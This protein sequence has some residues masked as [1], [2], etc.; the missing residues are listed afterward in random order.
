[1][2]RPL[3]LVIALD[4]VGI[5]GVL[6]AGFAHQQDDRELMIG[7]II[8]TLL[9]AVAGALTLVAWS[10]RRSRE[11]GATQRGPAVQEL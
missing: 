6:V 10:R 3:A 1:M 11:T 9:S 5:V 8:V 4:A 2:S 7:G